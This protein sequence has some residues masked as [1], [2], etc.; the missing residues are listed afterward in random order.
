MFQARQMNPDL[1]VE[2]LVYTVRKHMLT[3]LGGNSKVN[4]V[5]TVSASHCGRTGVDLENI[6]N[7]IYA[8]FIIFLSLFA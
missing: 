8:H 6:F 3:L 1:H 5:A 7:L 4:K 2:C